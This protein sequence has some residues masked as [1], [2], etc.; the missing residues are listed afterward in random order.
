[1]P[2]SITDFFK[3][4]YIKKQGR[5]EQ[6]NPNLEIP[7]PRYPKQNLMPPVLEEDE[8][9]TSDDERRRFKKLDPTTVLHEVAERLNGRLVRLIPEDPGSTPTVLI[10]TCM[11]LCSV[12]YYK[13][14]SRFTIY[15]TSTFEKY[16]NSKNTITNRNSI[17]GLQKAFEDIEKGYY[18]KVFKNN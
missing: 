2:K 4:T 8:Y 16:C 6:T 1:M 18:D 15:E 12:V 13:N 7:E 5:R 14:H 3:T 17:Y 11:G 9:E 10:G